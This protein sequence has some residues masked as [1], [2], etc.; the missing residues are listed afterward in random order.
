MDPQ[1]LESLT[2]VSCPACL[3]RLTHVC[4]RRA[5]GAQHQT[6]TADPVLVLCS[7]PRLGDQR[8]LPFNSS[9][10]KLPLAPVTSAGPVLPCS[11]RPVC[12]MKCAMLPKDSR[13][14]YK[15]S[16]L[17]SVSAH[18]N[19]KHSR[20]TRLLVRQH[21]CCNITSMQD[22][23]WQSVIQAAAIRAQQWRVWAR[24]CSGPMVQCCMVRLWA[25]HTLG[26]S[27]RPRADKNPKASGRR[28]LVGGGRSEE[29]AHF[30]ILS[31][32]T[33]APGSTAAGTALRAGPQLHPRS[34]GGLRAIF[35]CALRSS[36]H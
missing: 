20:C 3:R 14:V 31:T 4:P 2:P 18:S 23:E 25:V 6:T 33:A 32:T 5:S 17:A 10:S 30:E 15:G 9:P 13:L 24:S 19:V 16:R 11:A 12:I 21:K 28:C 26:S 1:E 7:S 36:G 8:Q 22:A 35:A 29:V 34:P 27:R